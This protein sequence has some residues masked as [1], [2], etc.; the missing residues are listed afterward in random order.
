LLAALEPS[1]PLRRFPGA[2]SNRSNP[3]KPSQT[4]F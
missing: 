3:V 1:I 2:N 4:I